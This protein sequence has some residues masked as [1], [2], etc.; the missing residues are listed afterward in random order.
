MP[1]LEHLLST[2]NDG[3]SFTLPV[4]TFSPERGETITMKID[5]YLRDT[6]SAKHCFL[7]SS[8]ESDLNAWISE[9][10]AGLSSGNAS[11]LL[12]MFR[13]LASEI[14]ERAN[15]TGLPSIESFLS[16]FSTIIKQ[17]C[18]RRTSYLKC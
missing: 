5:A 6:L 1:K 17:P 11:K 7:M 9:A 15:P 3:V 12:E 13:T 18:L 10:V 2:S 8:H 4:L 16:L 14:Y